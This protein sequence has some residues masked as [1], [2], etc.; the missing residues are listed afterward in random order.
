MKLDFSDVARRRRGK[1]EAELATQILM[2]RYHYPL[3]N[4]GK[5]YAKNPQTE[6]VQKSTFEI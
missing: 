2:V 4:L 6:L 1:M 5:N 3:Q